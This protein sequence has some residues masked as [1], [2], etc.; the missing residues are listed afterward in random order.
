MDERR[1]ES[2]FRARTRIDDARERLRERVSVVERTDP[3]AVADADGRTLAEPVD[4]S[5]FVPAESRADVDGFAV[6]AGETFGASDRSPATFTATGADPEPGEAVRVDAGDPLPE[7]ADA[8]VSVAGANRVGESVEVYDPVAEGEGVLAA[9]SDV[10]RGQRLHDAGHRLRPSDL[11]LLTAAGV[12][13]V[14]VRDRPRVAVVPTGDDLVAGDPGPGETVETDSLTVARLVDRWG[15]VADRRAPVGGDEA[16]LR[17][18]LREACADADV[19]VT[20]GGSGLGESD[21]VP[22]ALDAV[23]SVDVHGVAAVPARSV[24]LGAVDGTPVVV[25]PGAPAACVVG[26]VTFLRPAVTWADGRTV[27]EPPTSPA[28]LDRKIASDPGVRTYARVRFDSRDGQRVAVP[29][30]TDGGSL[31]SSVALADGWVEIREGIEG[32]PEGDL[33]AVQQWEWS[34]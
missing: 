25:L 30:H 9:G 8:V 4:A 22:E 17:S 21:R 12:D 18:A 2:G 11:G 23:G 32:L 16:S 26:A 27:D 28:M 10:E 20:T 31:L 6:A 24:G 29:V 5:R 33:V 13:E 14:T 1:R 7:G 3:V 34:A 19:V 15:G